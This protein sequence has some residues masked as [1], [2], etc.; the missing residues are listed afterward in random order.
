MT[1]YIDVVIILNFIFDYFILR[2]VNLVLKRNISKRRLLLGALTGEISIILLLFNYNI[3]ILLIFKIIMAIFINIIVFKYQSIKYTLINVSYFYMVSVILG[4]FI[5]S[6]K[7][8][9]LNYL[10][11]LLLVPFILWLYHKQENK[12]KDQYKN[13][14]L[15]KIVF[16]NNKELTINGYLDTG[17]NLIDPIS[18]KPI[19]ILDKRLTKGV[20]SIRSPI[21]VPYNALNYHSVLK[22]LKPKYIKVNTHIINNVLIGIM[23]NPINIDGVGCI[24]N[25]KLK[26]EIC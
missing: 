26:E 3:I 19:I 1:I 16:K 5:Y 21:Y 11:I 6:L 25:N 8:N 9:N 7:L 14:Y 4:G 10:I 23:D 24:L 13:Y 18:N 12:L 22:C 2:T 17:N 15:V 20:I